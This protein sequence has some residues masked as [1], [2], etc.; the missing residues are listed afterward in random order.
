MNPRATMVFLAAIAGLG[1][2]S[3]PASVLPGDVEIRLM[4]PVAW[5]GSEVVLRSSAFADY[6][7]LP[8][9]LLGDDTLTVVR[10]DDS[11]VS[12]TLPATSGDYEITVRLAGGQR[13][14]TL[15]VAGLRDETPIIALSGWALPTAPGSP[16]LLAYG[17]STLIQVDVR[18]AAVVDLGIPVKPTCLLSVG[19]TYRP[20]AAVASKRADCFGSRNMSWQV[21]PVGLL[22]SS[23]TLS[24]SY[25]R[26]ELSAGLWLVAGA[27]RFEF[28]P[29]PASQP[30]GGYA[31]EELERL[32]FS[33]DK[34]QV[35]PISWGRNTGD[36][37]VYNAAT[38]EESFDI[39]VDWVASAQFS[40]DGDTIFMVARTP[41]PDG[42]R[43][44]AA[45]AANGS[46]HRFSARSDLMGYDL[47]I[48][49]TRPLI[50]V[51]THDGPT[52]AVFDRATLAQLAVL[53]V[54]V[55]PG[56]AGNQLTLAI[57]EATDRLYVLSIRNFAISGS[58]FDPGS[59]SRVWEFDLAP[60]ATAS[61]VLGF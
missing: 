26:A 20:G 61:V 1:S 7:E 25:L 23:A 49:P 34:Q 39:G 32:I 36:Y 11:T 45:S 52:I 9:V 58:F 30:L 8:D 41:G 22:D 51:I 18:T 38:G 24:A 50:F 48:H 43:V 3:D 47:L 56:K 16:V 12:A 19:P 46:L 59:V 40:G 13:T 35:L 28:A 27:H 21:N 31:M 33:P 17:E 44:F 6:A 53:T 54:P 60:S 15:R 14:G 4:T 2:C 37:P 55:D 5:P 29:A 57:D 42:G 10:Q